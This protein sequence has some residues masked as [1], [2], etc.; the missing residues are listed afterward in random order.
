VHSNEWNPKEPDTAVRLLETWKPV[1]AKRTMVMLIDQVLLPKLTSA[2]EDWSPKQELPAH[3]WLHPWLPLLGSKLSPVYPLVRQKLGT[4]LAQWKASDE[5]AK[6]VLTP[7]RK[8]FDRASW[9]ALLARTVVPQLAQE[10]R[11]LVINPAQQ[12][13]E[14]FY[15][16]EVPTRPCCAIDRLLTLS[17]VSG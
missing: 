11:A 4:A 7:W 16:Y 9:D 2:V 5:S 1:F 6:A 13:M 10:L 12:Q 8:V 3:L 15:R 14:G 17:V